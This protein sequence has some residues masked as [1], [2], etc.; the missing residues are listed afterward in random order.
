MD[1]FVKIEIFVIF[2]KMYSVKISERPNTSG[3]KKSQMTRKADF[4]R[5]SYFYK[6]WLKRQNVT[7]KPNERQKIIQ[8]IVKKVEIVAQNE[9]GVTKDPLFRFC[10][11]HIWL[12]FG[13]S[14]YSVK[15]KIQTFYFPVNFIRSFLQST[16]KFNIP[17]VDRIILGPKFKGLKKLLAKNK[18]A[19]FNFRPIYT[20]CNFF[21]NHG[22]NGN[23]GQID[24]NSGPKWD[25]AHYLGLFVFGQLLYSAFLFFRQIFCVIF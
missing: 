21:T 18:R 4:L 24:R 8:F 13:Q 6:V 9:R 16:F 25:K 12:Y 2:Q 19:E 5:K 20:R 3:R 7:K 17:I 23:F 11:V 14:L 1:F 10:S 15:H 22:Q